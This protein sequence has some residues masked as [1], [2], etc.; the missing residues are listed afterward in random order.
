MPLRQRE[1][2]YHCHILPGIDDG[3]EEIDASV[4][5]ARLL[6]QAGYRQVYCTPHLIKGVYEVPYHEVAQVRQNLQSLLDRGGIDLRLLLGREYYLDEF[7]M[8]L[9]MND[10]PQL[11]EGTD[12][13]MIE[14]PSHASIDLAK[15]AFFTLRRKSIIPMI[16]HPERCL[17]L[18]M[19]RQPQ[20]HASDW[21]PWRSK[22]H[23]AEDE[24][25]GRS[26]LLNY[27]LQLG[28]QFQANLG[29]MNGQ[30]GER[31]KLNAASLHSNGILTHAGTDAHSPDALKSILG[32]L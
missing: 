20:H 23:H 16:A 22:R 18:E 9:I 30:Y 4:E 8:N 7:M 13:L 29:S 21:I 32:N 15:E 26:E 2:D 31:V 14:I 5:I 27:L 17:L 24:L 19:S 28:C 11:L 3:P 1:T 6:S 10:G 12:Y 25:Y